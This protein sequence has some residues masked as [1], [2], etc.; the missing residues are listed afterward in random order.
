MRIR[1]LLLVA[2]LS[3]PAF[4]QDKRAADLGKAILDA[5]LDPNECYR[6][7]DLQFTQE[8][9]QFFFTD[10]YLIFGRPV[11][12]R[13]LSAVFTSDVDG[14]DAEVLL[15]PPDGPERK[16]L[17]SH[18]G[19][20]NLSEHFRAAV[21]F[22][23]DDT[24]KNLLAELAAKESKR[25]PEMGTL[26]V[27][28]WSPVV[29][30]VS[31]S[32]ESR[33]VLDL[34][35]PGAGGHGFFGAVVSGA[36][37][38]NFDILRD[39]R[40]YEQMIA[41]QVLETNGVAAWETWTSFTARSHRGANSA[42]PSPEMKIS[43]YKIVGEIDEQLHMR[44]T[45]QIAVRT[46]VDTRDAL[47]FDLTGKMRAVNAKIDGVPVEV[48]E[49]NSVRSGMTR[50]SGNE[51]V[52]LI[53]AKPLAPGTDHEVEIE[54]E[55]DVIETIGKDLYYVGARGSWYPIRGLQFAGYDVTFRY[56]ARLQLVTAG[57]A[58]ED[59]TE[60]GI[61]TTRRV[62]EGNVRILGVNLGQYDRK[63]AA[64]GDIVAEAFA[65]RAVEDSLRSRPIAVTQETPPGIRSG[66]RPGGTGET[67]LITPRTPSPGEALEGIAAE[68]ASS[69]V[70]FEAR[71]GAPPLKHLVV[72][73]LPGRFGQGYPGMIYL[74]TLSYFDRESR[75]L[76]ALSQTT[77]FF[78]TDLMRIHEVAH[79]WWGNVIVPATYHHDWLMEAL[80]NYSALLY[81]EG[82]QGRKVFDAMLD[83][84][85][86]DLLRKN[87]EGNTLESAGPVV[88]GRRLE[89]AANPNAWATI[90]YG[91]GTWIMHMLRRRMGD[92]Q[93]FKMLG[94]LRRRYEWNVIETDQF[95]TL[96]AGYLPPGSKDPKLEVFFDQW[97]YSTGLPALKLS[98][99]VKGKPGAFKLTGTVTQTEV[100]DDFSLIVPVEVQ[101]GAKKVIVQVRTG[102][103]PAPFTLAVASAGAKAVLDPQGSV[104]RR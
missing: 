80:A 6:V 63:Q 23:T 74:S 3:F 52:L 82:T 2:A 44:A 58:K 91:K 31:T 53:P 33:L 1:R 97:V 104:L 45:V 76:A 50:D 78:F 51:L 75:Q 13:P 59:R 61:R 7:R 62:A 5:R 11:N 86:R 24:V 72:T 73:P 30:N 81:F 27:E 103:D 36:K 16:S 15:L 98:Y 35:T 28:K 67:V 95:R 29:K 89:T 12:G 94:E 68:V 40:S 66:R 26:L 38:G 83:E 21:F 54:I 96:A 57:E 71:F 100:G 17:A 85:R 39:D 47:P 64:K 20:P 43:H 90:I 101:V 46:S 79:Q 37:L 10:G 77:Q 88:Q 42:P 48:Y 84:Y 99:S 60:G 25:E 92:A 19:A 93:F 22:F 32:F 9:A 34:M 56:P 41:G 49:R 102:P 18:T 87:S 65:N 55:G 4:A 69:A 14:G 70:W 8:D